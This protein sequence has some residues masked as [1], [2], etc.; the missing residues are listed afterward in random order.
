MTSLVV[1]KVIWSRRVDIRK[2]GHINACKAQSDLA[3]FPVL[4]AAQRFP[5]AHLPA[6]QF[7]LSFSRGPS[8][9]AE[10]CFACCGVAWGVCLGR[11]LDEELQVI[12]AR[13][14]RIYSSGH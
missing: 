2:G 11:S 14:Q 8:H 9:E 10:R 1:G 3:I 7:Q 5:G 6:S 12:R 4:V 13:A